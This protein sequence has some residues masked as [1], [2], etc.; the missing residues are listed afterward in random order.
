VDREQREE[1]ARAFDQ[2]LR[3]R[4]STNRTSA[5]LKAF[6]ERGEA[7]EQENPEQ[8]RREET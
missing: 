5:R 8:E 1:A 7:G 6:M 4:L 2:A 3:E